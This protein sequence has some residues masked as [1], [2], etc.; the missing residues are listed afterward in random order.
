MLK[1]LLFALLAG[2]TGDDIG[3]EPRDDTAPEVADT[4]C[5]V[6]VHTPITETQTFGADVG[7]SAEVTD[8]TRVTVVTLHY[9]TDTAGSDDWKHH[10]MTFLEGVYSGT[11]KGSDHSGS[12]MDY[13]L[14][15]SDPAQNT[16][17]LP[18]EG[19]QDPY[20][21]RIAP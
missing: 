3:V 7:I 19:V 16:C 6:I 20:H 12:G 2:C 9:K 17:F 1:V 8:S 5:P 15:A 21:F 10:I 4:E 14:E 11:I 18:E 13:Y